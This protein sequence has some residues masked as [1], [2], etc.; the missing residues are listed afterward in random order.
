MRRDMRSGTEGVLS[1][2]LISMS[3]V[4]EEDEEERVQYY[5]CGSKR[6]R[7]AGVRNLWLFTWV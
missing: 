2:H 1:G 3:S 7:K 6:M 5:N 4:R